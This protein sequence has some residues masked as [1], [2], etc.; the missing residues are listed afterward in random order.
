MTPHVFLILT[1]QLTAEG[2]WSVHC[3]TICTKTKCC[4]GLVPA[5]TGQ[6]DAWWF[7]DPIQESWFT[8]CMHPHPARNCTI[9]AYPLSGVI[10]AATAAACQWTPSTGMVTVRRVVTTMTERVI[11]TVGHSR[12]CHGRGDCGPGPVAR[13]CGRVGR[14]TFD[15]LLCFDSRQVEQRQVG[16]DQGLRFT[17]LRPTFASIHL[18]TM[19]PDCDGFSSSTASCSAILWKQLAWASKWLLSTVPGSSELELF[20]WKFKVSLR[21]GPGGLIGS[22]CEPCGLSATVSDGLS[23]HQLRLIILSGKGDLAS[24]V[25]NW[26]EIAQCETGSHNL[27]PSLANTSRVTSILSRLR[28]WLLQFRIK[29]QKR[30]GTITESHKWSVAVY[31]NNIGNLWVCQSELAATCRQEISCL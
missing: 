23:W 18:G 19:F 1:C 30:T 31:S 14:P 7:V 6:M 25:L 17:P 21:P 27:E 13:G 8:C 11:V 22:H 12:H 15:S 26:L 2:D 24:H 10:A 5:R 28:V 29:R 16:V 9:T 3:R 20:D 4:D